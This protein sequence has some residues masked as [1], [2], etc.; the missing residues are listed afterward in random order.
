MTLISISITIR[1]NPGEC[2]KLKMFDFVVGL[3]ILVSSLWT[4]GTKNE[5]TRAGLLGSIFVCAI[6]LVAVGLLNTFT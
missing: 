2:R 4:F 3:W 6:W 5:N 1:L